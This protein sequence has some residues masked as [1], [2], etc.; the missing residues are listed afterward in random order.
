MISIHNFSFTYRKKAVLDN[1]NL[2]FKAGQI[3]GT[4]YYVSPDA[5]ANAALYRR[6]EFID[7]DLPDT[8]RKIFMLDMAIHD[9]NTGKNPLKKILLLSKK[10]TH[11]IH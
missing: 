1:L 2:Q 10:T 11:R 7:K 4:G 6:S 9:L 5:I 3:R 8:F